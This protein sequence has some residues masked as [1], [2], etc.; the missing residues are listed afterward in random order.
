M[1]RGIGENHNHITTFR[2]INILIARTTP[3][4]DQGSTTPLKLLGRQWPM[5]KLSE[6]RQGKGRSMH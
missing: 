3:F 6:N 5:A 4:F 2:R 1:Q